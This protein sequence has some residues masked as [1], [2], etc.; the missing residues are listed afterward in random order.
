MILLRTWSLSSTTRDQGPIATQFAQL[1]RWQHPPCAR[2]P[3]VLPRPALPP[4]PACA[5]SPGP[6]P[7]LAFAVAMSW[8]RMW[9]SALCSRFGRNV[10]LPE[11]TTCG[12]GASPGSWDALGTLWPANLHAWGR[13]PSNSPPPQPPLLAAAERAGRCCRRPPVSPLRRR[14]GRCCRGSQEGP[15]AG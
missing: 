9:R 5:P 3:L 15:A 4:V 6:P 11:T 14:R 8:T 7:L 2:A 10:G 13:F 12:Q 1:R